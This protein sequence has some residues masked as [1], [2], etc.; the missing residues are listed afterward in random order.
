MAETLTI[1]HFFVDFFF[2]LKNYVESVPQDLVSGSEVMRISATDID[3]GVN[4]AI[5]YDLSPR[6][7]QDSNYFSIDQNTGVIYLSNRAIDVSVHLCYYTIFVIC[8]KRT[9]PLPTSPLL[10]RNTKRV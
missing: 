6:V 2:L 8:I 4:S 1:Y 10:F 7:P 5:V 9:M 3:D